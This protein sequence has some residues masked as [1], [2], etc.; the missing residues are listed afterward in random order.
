MI[1]EAFAH[2]GSYLKLSQ[3]FYPLDNQGMALVGESNRLCF[4]ERMSD[5]IKA[6]GIFHQ[7]VVVTEFEK[8]AFE[9]NLQQ[10]LAAEKKCD[11]LNK[12]EI[13]KRYPTLF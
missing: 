8:S 12:Q 4:I 3:I 11:S 13:L 7:P 10:F 1:T 9:S 5:L 2:N 6:H